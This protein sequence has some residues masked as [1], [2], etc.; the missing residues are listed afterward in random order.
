VL[1]GLDAVAFTAGIGT[2]ASP[3]RAQ[4]LAGL[5]GLGITLD[6]VANEAASGREA[7][8]TTES[9]AIS[10]WVVPTNEELVI[11]QDTQKLALAARQSPFV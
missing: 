4:V 9:S 5:E 1:G 11:A 6:P 3:I 8:I 10:A 7:C 2:F